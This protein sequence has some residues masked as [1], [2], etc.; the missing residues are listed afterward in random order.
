MKRNILLFIIAIFSLLSCAYY[1]G[2][3]TLSHLQTINIE[4]FKV[5]TE[6]FWLGQKSIDFFSD[7]FNNKNIKTVTKSPDCMLKGEIISYT[8]EILDY[9]ADDI[10]ESYHL[11]MTFKIDFIDLIKNKTLYSVK[12][13][14]FDIKYDIGD[15]EEPNVN[16][17]VTILESENNNEGKY[18]KI[19]EPKIY[20]ELYDEIIKTTFDSW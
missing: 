12:S 7:E 5:K 20:Q 19:I 4:V 18:E 10:V 16:V 6:E 2:T 8:D 17:D 11:K 14:T 13:K 9:D 3:K 15:P 1:V